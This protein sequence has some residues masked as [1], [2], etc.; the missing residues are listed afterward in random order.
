MEKSIDDIER[1]VKGQILNL[2]VSV[3]S[4]EEIE[5][6][7]PVSWNHR[8]EQPVFEERCVQVADEISE[9]TVWSDRRNKYADISK[10]LF[11]RIS[12]TLDLDKLNEMIDWDN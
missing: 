7:G 5:E 4:R 2:E 6:I 9:I 1:E 12:K 11:K 3:W 8:T 10:R